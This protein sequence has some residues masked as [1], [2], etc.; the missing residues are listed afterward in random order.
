[1][2]RRLSAKI[3]DPALILPKPVA[4]F[5]EKRTPRI[6]RIEQAIVL[7][8]SFDPASTAFC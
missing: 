1:M 2:L 6:R 7:L 8:V 3:A 4:R 5:S